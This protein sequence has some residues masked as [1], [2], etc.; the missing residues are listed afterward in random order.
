MLERAGNIENSHDQFISYK[1]EH[2][3]LFLAGAEGAPASSSSL[4][5]PLLK[6]LKNPL[7]T[8]T[9]GL[10]AWQWNLEDK[11]DLV[12]RLWVLLAESYNSISLWSNLFPL[13]RFSSLQKARIFPSMIK[14][15]VKEP[16]LI[17][18]VLMKC[19]SFVVS[20]YN[21]H[22][23]FCGTWWYLLI[24]PPKITI[25]PFVAVPEAHSLGTW[26]FASFLHWFLSKSYLST[27]LRYLRWSPS[28]IKP[29]KK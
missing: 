3:F 11:I 4:K 12:I 7:N 10:L 15:C 13:W 21:S 28:N 19:H 18:K 14:S 9:E 1:T 27:S 26:I 24:S 22:W 17:F 8:F 29:L 2:F 25:F 23:Q 6:L 5:F 16:V 20:S